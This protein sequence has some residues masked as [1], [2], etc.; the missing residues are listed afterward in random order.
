[1]CESSSREHSS[2]AN[3]GHLKKNGQ[4]SNPA[5]NFYWRMSRLPFLLWWSNARLRLHSPSDQYTKIL[6][7]NFLNKNNC[8]SS[9][10][11]HKTVHKMSHSYWKKDKANSFI[12]FVSVLW[13]INALRFSSKMTVFESLVLTW[14]W[15]P[16]QMTT[17]CYVRVNSSWEHPPRKTPGIWCTMSSKDRAFSSKK[18]PGPPGNCK[19]QKSCFVTSCRHFRRDNVHSQRFQ[20]PSFWNR[21]RIYQP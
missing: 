14:H 6:V 9:K 13:S 1:M 11:L 16:S 18:C 4:M 19:Q 8:F 7:A 3:P 17:G 2:P 15:A 10:E 12:A 21:K 20:T 5:G